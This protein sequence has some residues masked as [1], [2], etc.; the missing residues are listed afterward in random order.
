MTSWDGDPDMDPTTEPY[1][2]RSAPYFL[3]VVFVALA[4]VTAM[5]LT[6]LGCAG[7]PDPAGDDAERRVVVVDG[8][9]PAVPPSEASRAAREV[10][11]EAAPEIVILPEERPKRKTRVVEEVVYVDAPEAPA[12]KGESADMT[13]AGSALPAPRPEGG[14]SVLL[15]A[16]RTRVEVRASNAISTDASRVGDPV[17][18]VVSEPVVVDGEVVVPEGSEVHGRVTKVDP[19][20][21]PTRRPSMEVVYDRIE[22]PDGRSIDIEAR[23]EGEVGEVVQHPR[24][25]HDGMR[26][27]LLGAGAGAAVGAATGGRKGAAVGAIVGAAMGAGV[28]HGGVDWCAAVHPGD[29]MTIIFGRDVLVPRGPV[30]VNWAGP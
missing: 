12:P 28:G 20:E 27:V 24:G 4:V 25:D 14:E 18:A 7:E 22:T 8:D 5:I 29:P 16:R 2:A 19:G 15:P 23:A 13:G 26:N 17:T 11:P 21:Y 30:I 3:L 6:V 9:G 10:G 1:P